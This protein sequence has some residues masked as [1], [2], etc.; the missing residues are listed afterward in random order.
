MRE[1]SPNHEVEKG[2]GF[3]SIF[4]VAC[5]RAPRV[6]F[7][8]ALIVQ[9]DLDPRMRMRFSAQISTEE[10]RFDPCEGYS[11][12]Y[13]VVLN[14]QMEN[15]VQTIEIAGP[16]RRSSSVPARRKISQRKVS[17][18]SGRPRRRRDPNFTEEEELELC[19]IG[20]GVKSDT[21]RREEE[22]LKRKMQRKPSRKVSREGDYVLIQERKGVLMSQAGAQEVI[23]ERVLI[24]SDEYFY[25]MSQGL[26]KTG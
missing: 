18:S 1:K 5:K 26:L 20:L 17:Y 16:R 25:M 13:E 23:E 15:V 14:Y 6:P 2:R 3:T 9:F 22:E 7:P 21:A 10:G 8:C 19:R 4:P 12:S 24:G 11:S